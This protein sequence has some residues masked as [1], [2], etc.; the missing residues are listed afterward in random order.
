[1]TDVSAGQSRLAEPPGSS[2]GPASPRSNDGSPLRVAAALSRVEARR[3]VRSPAT[4]A[5]IALTAIVFLAVLADGFIDADEWLGLLSRHF[6]LFLYPL[7]GMVLVAVNRAAL[8]PRR[9]G[10]DELFESLPTTRATR[11]AALVLALRGPILV[12]AGAVVALAGGAWWG[13]GNDAG[14]FARAANPAPFGDLELAP[15]LTAVVLVGCAGALGLLLA[16]LAPWG[17]VPIAA[18]IVVA[19]LSLFPNG[20]GNPTSFKA[21]SPYLAPPELPARFAPQPLWPHLVYV[22][23]LGVLAVG[24]TFIADGARR[25]AVPMLGAAAVLVVG[26][27][28]WQSQPLDAEISERVAQLAS[29]PAEEHCEERNGVTY[30]AFDGLDRWI[31]EWA[32]VVSSVHDKVPRVAERD[33]KVMQ[34]FSLESIGEL[35]PAIADRTTTALVTSGSAEAVHPSLAWNGGEATTYLALLTGQ[36]AVGLPG[37]A[38]AGGEPCF[39]GGQV[40]AAIAV[41]L[42]ATVDP[43]RTTAYVRAHITPDDIIQYRDY[44]DDRYTDLGPTAWVTDQDAAVV[45]D[46]TDLELALALVA[47]PA[48]VDSVLAASWDRLVDP[49]TTTG[50]LAE[51]LG[52]SAGAPG[53]GPDGLEKCD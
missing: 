11:S 42:A 21:L 50:E 53:P 52:L 51:I 7:C 35:D 6:P 34:V 44:G 17:L 12:G 45:Y 9:D 48:E 8:R 41:Y 29:G 14:F 15:M 33:L 37:V 16:R 18:L 40:R 25:W 2:T 20:A 36:W 43:G 47:R 10:T 27:A 23:G 19:L 26:G 30:C 3:I 1:M 28:V 32:P 13:A 24:L 22:I 38:G 31:D 5:G 39:A 4:A 49:T 46:D